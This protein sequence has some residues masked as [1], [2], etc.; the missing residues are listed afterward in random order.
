M[1]TLAC[2]QSIKLYKNL[3]HTPHAAHAYCVKL[4]HQEYME[5]CMTENNNIY[6]KTVIEH[7][8][9]GLAHALPIISR[10]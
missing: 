4:Q 1:L 7:T 5:Q 6:L 3:T 8:S 10:H 9:V 2:C